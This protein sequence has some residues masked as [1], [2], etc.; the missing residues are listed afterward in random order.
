MVLSEAMVSKESK[1]HPVEEVVA[2][3]CVELVVP[4]LSSNGCPVGFNEPNLLICSSAADGSSISKFGCLTA[5]TIE[6]IMSRL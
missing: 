6:R 4:S 1:D 3:F 5:P 2:S